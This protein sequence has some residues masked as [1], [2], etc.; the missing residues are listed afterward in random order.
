M[1]LPADTAWEA[2][3]DRLAAESVTNKLMLS[4]SEVFHLSGTHAGT[5]GVMITG[6]I[7]G[8]GEIPGKGV[9]AETAE[10]APT[11][12]RWVD[13][14]LEIG[15]KALVIE[16]SS[17]G[18]SATRRRFFDGLSPREPSWWSTT[19]RSWGE[20]WVP[21]LRDN[22]VT[23]FEDDPTSNG[24]NLS[25]HDVTLAV[26]GD[27]RWRRPD[28]VG[29]F[30]NKGQSVG[31][32]RVINRGT[33]PAWCYFICEAPGRV[34]LPDGPNAVITPVDAT[35]HKDF[36]GLLGLFN[37]GE[38]LP[39]GQRRRRDPKTVV[40]L[41]LYAGEHTL[42]DTDPRHKLAIA[43][44]DPVDNGWLE[45]INNAELLKILTG[46][47]GERATTVMERLRGQGFRVPIP[48][49]SEATLPV[50]HS[51]YGGRI[52]CVVPQRF[53]HAL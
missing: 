32:I 11:F 24:D 44:S 28:Y 27:P 13:G 19:T 39:W 20:V 33:V 14:K 43:A 8:L 2:L 41:T 45:W 5:E 10:G 9:W 3:P 7:E 35:E 53:D 42:V 46:N 25:I 34:L 31:S 17:F 4:N 48:A 29:M 26:S 21:V 6:A 37:L 12:E 38:L 18:W 1:A 52:W 22:L 23:V 16:D 15:F 47:A 36:P 51:R 30:Q 40:D 50:S 49:R